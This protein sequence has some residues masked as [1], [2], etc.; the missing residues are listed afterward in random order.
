VTRTSTSR[1]GEEEEEGE[2]NSDDGFNE[3]K[4]KRHTRTPEVEAYSERRAGRRLRKRVPTPAPD[5][6]QP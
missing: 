2:R 6:S 1:V 5:T 4:V 3:S